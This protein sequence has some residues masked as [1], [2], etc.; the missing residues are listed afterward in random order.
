MKMK[1]L[2]AKILCSAVALAIVCGSVITGTPLLAKADE[3]ITKPAQKF[4]TVDGKD[5]TAEY[6]IV[7]GDNNDLLR[8]SPEEKATEKDGKWVVEGAFKNKVAINDLAMNLKLSSNLSSVEF[9]LVTAPY[10]A[11]GNPYVDDKGTADPKDD[12]DAV[13]KEVE[14]SV[15]FVNNGSNFKVVA[16][17]QDTPYTVDTNIFLLKT[18]V[19]DGELTLDIAG[20]TLTENRTEKLVE[21]QDKTMATVKVKFEY[22]SKPTATDAGVSFE[23]IDQ[24]VTATANGNDALKQAFEV[25]ANG[26]LKITKGFVIDLN[27]ETTGCKIDGDK[28]TLIKN[29]NYTIKYDSYRLNGGGTPV[30]KLITKD[31]ATGEAC[32]V[33]A[34]DKK[35]TFVKN[36]TGYNIAINDNAKDLATYIVDVVDADK[37]YK[38]DYATE[39]A[40]KNDVYNNAPEY[41]DDVNAL[42]SFQVAVNDA[43]QTEY[44]VGGNKVKKSIRV[45]SGKYLNLPSMANIVTDNVNGYGTLDATVY[46]MNVDTDSAWSTYSGLKVPVKK[47]GEYKFFVVFADDYGNTI[48]AEKN[49]YN[50]TSGEYFYEK[51]D[52]GVITINP[53]YEK[54]IFTFEV[55]DDAPIIVSAGNNS[56][57]YTGVK[58][59]AASFSIE[60]SDERVVTY[61]LEYKVGDE[62][63]EIKTYA[64]DYDDYGYFTAEEIQA[65]GYDGT[66]TFT[67]NKAGT[68]KITCTVNQTNVIAVD[69]AETLITV[70]DVATVEPYDFWFENNVWSFVFLGIGT[71]ALAGVI[72][73]LCIKP[74]ED[75]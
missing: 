43:T 14:N 4:F 39:Q 16:N 46:Y 32:A 67:P 51:D 70:N 60:A 35:I 17:G 40:Y 23:Y 61:K 30:V 5:Y 20:N 24:A 18:S 58:N 29:V 12:V 8:F 45:G 47:A 55:E 44:E 6:V 75:K 28:L 59:T 72:V 22:A 50:E 31:T 53:N 49:D 52:N 73:L 68:Y 10:I 69:S 21:C 7:E 62:W 11:S 9:T 65:I 19:A 3:P 74:K 2:F 26:A 37:F 66:L 34:E 13:A 41:I 56:N 38:D 64:N 33:N 57:W 36:G 63:K 54:F 1:S 48:D 15:K 42:K 27:A 25:D 71:L